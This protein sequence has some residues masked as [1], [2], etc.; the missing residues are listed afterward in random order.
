MTPSSGTWA[1]AE[2]RQRPVLIKSKSRTVLQCSRAIG[3]LFVLAPVLLAP[4]CF[5][6]Q[7]RSNSALDFKEAAALLQQNRLVEARALAMQGLFADPS[8]SRDITCWE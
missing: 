3:S 2:C 6:L 4:L 5:A 8:S 7:S 1:S